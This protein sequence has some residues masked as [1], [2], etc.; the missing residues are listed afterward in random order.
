[1]R[2]VI[3]SGVSTMLGASLPAHAV[4]FSVF[5]S[6]KKSFGADSTEHT[7]IASGTNNALLL[8]CSML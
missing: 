3:V 1:M 4:Y 6:A 7:P 8:C 5:E 2:C